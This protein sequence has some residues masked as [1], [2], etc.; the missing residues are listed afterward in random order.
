[1]LCLLAR[2]SIVFLQLQNSAGVVRDFTP[3]EI[4][5]FFREV[6]RDRYCIPCYAAI[7]IPW[8]LC[9]LLTWVEVAGCLA[10]DR[11]LARQSFHGRNG[12]GQFGRLCSQCYLDGLEPGV[13]DQI[14]RVIV[15]FFFWGCLNGVHYLKESSVF[16]GIFMGIMPISSFFYCLIAF[17]TNA[18]FLLDHAV[19]TYD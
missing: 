18:I 2:R 5:S 14:D 8:I 17:W 7:G 15:S 9:A 10:V 6:A 12:A 11:V 3:S 19:N 13:Q 1:M 4:I 16:R